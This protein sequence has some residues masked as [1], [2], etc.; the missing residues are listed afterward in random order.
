MKIPKTNSI[1]NKVI[2]NAQKLMTRDSAV[3]I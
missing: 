2:P 1:M 3:S